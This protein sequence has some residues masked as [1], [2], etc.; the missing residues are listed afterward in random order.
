MITKKFLLPA[1]MVLLLV[2]PGCIF[3]PDD[4]PDDNV[5]P[6]VVLPFPG[7]KD[8]VMANF[9]TIYE[10]M[11]IAGFRNLLH[12]DYLTIL[13]Q[14]TIDAFPDVGETLDINEELQIHER[15]F[16]GQSGTDH[17][18]ELTNP[19]SSIVFQDPEQV[20]NWDVSPADDRIPNAD[21]ARF[22]VLFEFFRTGDTTL[23]V[24]GDIIFYLTSRDSLHEGIIK[25]YY[26]MIGQ[27]DLTEDD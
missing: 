11:D 2:Q 23:Q 13:Q 4:D 20:T 14:S 1:L 12:P 17:L 3:S 26:Q 27:V 15:M 21:F 19:I 22:N 8:Q 6:P 25:P 10:N 18:G 24:K 9:R 7:T 16:S 5:T